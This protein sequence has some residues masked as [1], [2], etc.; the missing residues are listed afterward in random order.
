MSLRFEL[1]GAGEA[2]FT[3]RA[4]GNLS[5]LR[6]EQPE[7]GAARRELLC[8]QLG[9][10]WL[11]ASR[12]V[13]GTVVHRVR[14]ESGRGGQALTL[15]ADGHATSMRGIGVMVL[16]A[17]CLPVAIGAPGAVAM[18]HAGWRGLASGVLEEGVRTLR[19]LID[20]DPAENKPLQITAVIGPSAGSCCYEVGE[21]VH[22]EFDN[23]HREG[24]KIDLSAIAQERMTAAGVT[25]VHKIERC[26]IC[27]PE[28][29]SYRREGQG[30]GRQAGIAWLT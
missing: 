12:Q 14:S 22:A 21:D 23:R 27:D 24:R 7:S 8:N 26:T 6:G 18:V 4:Q 13:H 11:C 2:L 1:P 10:R 29:F 5:T 16:A 19:E 15:D 3:T 28:F 9:L 30:A 25:R 17:D 20:A